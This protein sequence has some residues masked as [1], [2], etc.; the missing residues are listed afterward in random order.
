MK[1]LQ[2]CSQAN[3]LFE[4]KGVGVILTVI[5]ISNW[6]IQQ[7]WHLKFSEP[8]NFGQKEHKS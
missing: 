6:T 7:F 1:T 4:H 2:P 3:S 8:K 5:M